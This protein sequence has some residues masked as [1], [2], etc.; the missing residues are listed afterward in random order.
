MTPAGLIVGMP[1]GH[2]ALLV[3]RLA[4]RGLAG[5]LSPRTNDERKTGRRLFTPTLEVT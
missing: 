3:I 5:P 1:A 4:L 2:R